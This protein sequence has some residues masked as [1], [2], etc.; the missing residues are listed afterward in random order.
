MKRMIRVGGRRRGG[1]LLAWALPLACLLPLSVSARVERTADNGGDDPAGDPLDT[2]DYG[3]G[4]GQGER[5]QN[6]PG[7]PGIQGAVWRGPV[8]DGR[9]V[10]LVPFNQG[11]LLTFRLVII[12]EAVVT[13]EAADAR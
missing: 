4:G 12:D 1:R 7:W 8:I 11:G 3:S 2:N 9:R 13:R 10:L 5:Y 6:D